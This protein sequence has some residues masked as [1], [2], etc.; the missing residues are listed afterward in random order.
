MRRLTSW[1]VLWVGALAL[2]PG[3]APALAQHEGH[4]PEP[5]PSVR[6]ATAG[7]GLSP[8]ELRAD[9]GGTLM[10]RMS[11]QGSGTSLQPESSPMRA[12]A[13]M[14]GDWLWSVH[15]NAV[16]AWNGATGGRGYGEGALSNWAMAMGARPLG[17]GVLTFK[18]MGSLEFLT[19]PP[20]GTPQLFQ[21]GETFG[22]RP[23][24]DRQHPHDLFIEFALRYT[25]PLS[26]RTSLFVYGGPVG[27]PALGPNTFMHRVSAADNALA[28]LGHHLQD[29][30]HIAMGVLTA[31]A[32]H[33]R[34][35]LEGSVFNG[36][37]PDENR[38]DIERGALDSYSARLSVAP[39]PNWTLQVSSAFLTQPEALEQG[40][41]V[42][43][44][45]SFHHNL[46]FGRNNWS[47]GLVWG[48]NREFAHT[49]TL[50]S[51]GVLLES[52]L[53]IGPQ[54]QIYG[55][56]EAVD[57]IGLLQGVTGDDEALHRVHALTLGACRGIGGLPAF[58]LGLGG[59]VT[60]H[61]RPADLAPFYGA[62]PVAYRVYLRLRPP[63][64]GAM[65]H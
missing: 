41:A 56:F 40:D 35:Q 7:I 65:R 64:M 49:P 24:I 34:W 57:K 43:T 38:W 31:G 36:R 21:T 60:L 59:D 18:T 47:S 12:T 42:R 17:P 27:E 2:P 37:E 51:N 46:P 13:W 1:G 25:L 45:A 16:G 48:Q 11:L 4:P 23:L 44:T 54:D 8:Q 10:R 30:T 55:R 14:A 58:D 20:G 28:P 62:T 6:P 32:Q 61:A 3:A 9:P 33:E 5:A 52:A 19:L 53:D 26:E 63:R 50:V 15:A 29:S 39:T 22:G